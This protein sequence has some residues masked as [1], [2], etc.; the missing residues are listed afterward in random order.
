VVIAAGSWSSLVEGIHL[1]AA[2]VKPVRGQIVLLETRPPAVH[3][4]VVTAGGYLVGRADGRVLCGSTMEHAGYDKSV[5]A[6]GLA[7]VLGLALA[8]VPALA[9]APVIETWANFRPTTEDRL[10]IIGE[11]DIAGLVFATGH[12]RNGILLSPET[13]MIV[14]DVITG[15]AQHEL[16][17]F[18]PRRLFG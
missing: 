9:S 11:G 17:A 18:S 2:T 4:T 6:G 8:V 15:S 5:T 10:P 13:A 7:H 12:F 16:E 1:P 3:G 14:R